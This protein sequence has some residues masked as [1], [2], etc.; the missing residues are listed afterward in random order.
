MYKIG[1]CGLGFVGNAIYNAF[2]N[3]ENIDFIIY[4]KYKNINDFQILLKADFIFICL[5][6]NYSNSLKTYDMT[7]INSTITNLNDCNYDGIIIIKSTVLPN[8]C[9]EQ[10][11]KYPNLKIINN[12]EFLTARTAIEDFKNQKHIILGYTN[13]SKDNI[14]L[15]K[16]F[17][18]SEFP[19]AIISITNSSES[20]L[21]K[22]ACNSFYATKI[23]Y[24]TEIYL[25]CQKI[26]ISYE[27]VKNMM[28]KNDWINPMHTTIPGP[29]NNISFGG[30]CFPKDI[31]AFNQYLEDLDLP[32][33]VINASICERNELR[34]D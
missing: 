17:Y 1:I 27:N 20:A 24:F 28:L 26:N 4:D 15:I 25:L 13:Q 12:P 11:D 3:K 21:I 34:K 29:D 14:E 16:T 18:Q 31:S 5:P 6:T 22:I 8:Y 10:N 9:S 19:L 30:A 7:E 33:D 32:H 23:Q 2:N